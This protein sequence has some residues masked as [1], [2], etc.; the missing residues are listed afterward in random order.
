MRPPLPPPHP[1]LPLPLP[2]PT[3]PSP[4]LRKDKDDYHAPF[5]HIHPLKEVVTDQRTN[6]PTEGQSHL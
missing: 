2:T 1:P 6:G 4:P 5:I 3:L